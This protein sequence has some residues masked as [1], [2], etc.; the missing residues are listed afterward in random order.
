MAAATANIDINA[1]VQCT[2]AGD[3]ATFTG[4]P[5]ITSSTNLSS[6][7]ISKVF[8]DIRAA[9]AADPLDLTSGLVDPYGNALVFTAVKLVCI[10]NTSATATLTV[11]GGSNPVFGS[12][13][14]TIKAGVCLPILSSFTVDGT[15]KILTITPSAAATYQII[16]AG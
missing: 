15:H 7:D 16:I 13:Q 12:D 9:S 5:K 10:K 4:T 6:S 1:S 14:Y 11:G 2:F 8:Q 3:L